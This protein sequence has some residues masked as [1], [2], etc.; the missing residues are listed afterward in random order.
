VQWQFDNAL[1]EQLPGCERTDNSTRQTHAAYAIARPTPVTA[2]RVLAT[3]ADMAARLGLTDTDLRTDNF[4]QMAAGNQLMVGMQPIAVNYGGHQFGQWAGQL[5]D[6]RA[7][8]IAEVKHAN[9]RFEL[10]LKGAGPTPFSRHADG[11][12][13]LRSSLREFVCAEAMYA[14]GVPTTRALCLIGTGETVVRDMFYDGN[15]QAEPGAIV[16]RVAPSFLRFGNIELPCARGDIALTRRWV[17]F[18]I[19]RDLPHL[20]GRAHAIEDWFAEVCLRTAIMIAHWMRVGFVHGVMN[21]DNMSLL[22][23]T[24]DYGP[25][26]WLENFDADFT[27]NTTDRQHR[28]AFGRQPDVAH[29]NLQC[30][31]RAIAPLFDNQTPLHAGLQAYADTFNAKHAEF[32]AHKLGFSD[33]RPE[34]HSLQ[35]HLY[36]LLH[37]LE[38]DFVLFFRRLADCDF[39]NPDLQ[40]F[41]DAFYNTDKIQ[42]HGADLLDWLVS[43]QVRRGLQH[44]DSG[45]CKTRMDAV[46]PLYVPRN[47]LAQQAIDATTNGDHSYLARWMQA[48]AKPYDVQ[49]GM[50]EF[51]RRRPD[52][53]KDR[54]GCSMLS[55][56]S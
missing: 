8:T 27:P 46:N 56:S 43:Y 25:Y 4:L 31:A 38:I 42:K 18:C 30:L 34:D 52:W 26:G 13:V 23:L 20:Q 7:I 3:S 33:A 55:C 53:A 47:Y 19:A 5:G 12:A 49:V 32:S 22:G 21:T 37:D 1:F 54:A 16:L 28:Y 15:P 41:S 11:R 24:L 48:L 51:Q 6:G 35:Q 10:Q 39:A 17:E 45:T 29:W 44:D 50:D 2:P 9:Q 40:H 14:M 36:R